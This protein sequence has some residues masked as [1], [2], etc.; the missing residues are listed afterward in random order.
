VPDTPNAPAINLLEVSIRAE[1]ARHIVTGFSL[2]MPTLADLWRQVDDALADI[3]AL[4]AEISCLR[5]W[6]TACRIDRA[7]LAA[8][9][10]ITIAAYHNGEPNPL[11]YL[12]DELRAQG[13]GT[14]EP[15]RWDI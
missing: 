5:D 10:R 2:T 8:V 13:F 15:E 9:G 3:S 12:R 14:S 7:N 11:A 4:T 1:H 6:L